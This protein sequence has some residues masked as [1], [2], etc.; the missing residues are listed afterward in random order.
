MSK[1]G[2]C[3]KPKCERRV[4]AGVPVARSQASASRVPE[5]QQ[6]SCRGRSPFQSAWA[7]M[8]AATV[9]CMGAS[10]VFTR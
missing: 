6:G 4:W 2:S 1:S 10:T 5:P 8:A 9:S 3:M 7:R